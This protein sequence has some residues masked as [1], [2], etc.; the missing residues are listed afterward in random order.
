MC[1]FYRDTVG[2][3]LAVLARSHELG[4]TVMPQRFRNMAELRQLRGRFFEEMEAQ[5]ERFR[6]DPAAV[7][8]WQSHLAYSKRCIGGTYLPAERVAIEQATEE[9]AVCAWTAKD[10]KIAPDIVEGITLDGHA[11]TLKIEDQP[12]E[13]VGDVSFIALQERGTASVEQ[14]WARAS[15]YA[16]GGRG[17]N[18][19]CAEATRREGGRQT[20]TQYL[21]AEASAQAGEAVSSPVEAAFI[22][23]KEALQHR[24][25]C[26]A[27]CAE[28]CTNPEHHRK[29]SLLVLMTERDQKPRKATLLQV[30]DLL[31]ATLLRYL[32][33]EFFGSTTTMPRDHSAAPEKFIAGVMGDSLLNDCV[34]ISNDA[35]EAT[36]SVT[37]PTLRALGKEL[38]R[39]ILSSPQSNHVP[40]AL[41]VADA[42]GASDHLYLP[43]REARLEIVISAPVVDESMES[44]DEDLDE[45]A[46][47]PLCNIR[48]SYEDDGRK[49]LERGDMPVLMLPTGAGKTTRAAAIIADDLS[50]LVIVV[51]PTSTQAESIPRT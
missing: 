49:A 47:T 50:A 33:R 1:D 44:S 38:R 12:V 41:L 8:A 45:H 2:N 39:R 16:F 29:V 25:E 31:L 40:G 4:I 5:V 14:A 30:A 24:G 35:K 7:A 23:R 21:L 9:S 17:A 34:A 37:F 19:A 32:L 42:L 28:D 48:T 11:V 13:E 43:D 26:T 22:V 36:N 3:A 15:R 27:N 46:A 18:A 20:G 51:V 10:V 6:D